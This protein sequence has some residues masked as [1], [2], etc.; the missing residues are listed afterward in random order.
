MDPGWKLHRRVF[1][2]PGT[3]ASLAAWLEGRNGSGNDR[4]HYSFRK[5]MFPM[6]LNVSRTDSLVSSYPGEYVKVMFS[7]GLK[8][9]D[10]F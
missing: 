2:N 1:L 6:I 3:P 5:L 7:I 9:F 8:V 4:N 10:V